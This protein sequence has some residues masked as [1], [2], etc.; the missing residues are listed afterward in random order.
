MKKPDDKA[1]PRPLKSA[2]I[3][4]V[5]DHNFVMDLLERML[6]P[7]VGGLHGARSAE[8]AF[9]NLE[10]TPGLAHVAI[11][12]YHLVGMDGLKFIEK[13][14]TSK[15]ETLKSLPVV[16]LT[17]D[18]DMD[19]YRRAARLGISAYLK[20]PVGVDSLV[21]ALEGAL[22]GRRVAVPRL[23]VDPSPPSERALAMPAED[24][25]SAPQTTAST[26]AAKTLA[27]PAGHQP[28]NFKT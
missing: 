23:D 16:M 20:K 19:V 6:K 3:L 22:A 4:V 25:P 27:P 24:S 15:V 21:E 10:K 28:I 7:R 26:G 1:P 17:G 8:D 12:D 14:R 13:L 2:S 18:N 11:V 9:Y 5:E